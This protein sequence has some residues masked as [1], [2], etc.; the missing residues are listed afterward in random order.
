MMQMSDNDLRRLIV[1]AVDSVPVP[2]EQLWAVFQK[3]LQR[4]LWD[5]EN[6]SENKE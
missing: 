3:I 4:T 6:L 2:W 5:R 1:T